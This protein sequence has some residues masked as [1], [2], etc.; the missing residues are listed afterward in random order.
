M[1]LFS[2]MTHH[3]PHTNSRAPQWAN[4]PVSSIFGSKLPNEV[5]LGA[6]LWIHGHTH[7]SSDYRIGDSKRSVSRPPPMASISLKTTA[8]RSTAF[9]S[10]ALRSGLTSCFS[11]K[12]GNP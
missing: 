5:L 9:D 12:T 11:V 10:S 4:D 3:Y 7:D 2:T 6:K 1:M 8:S